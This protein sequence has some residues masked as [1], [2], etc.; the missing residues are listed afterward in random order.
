[1]S[2][3]HSS[4]KATALLAELRQFT[5]DLER[6]RHPLN[7]RLLYT[8]G[9]QFLAESAGA[10]W[11]IDAIASWIGTP[12]YLAAVVTDERINDLH[13]WKLAVHSN[14]SATL[15]AVADADEPPFLVQQIAYTDFCLESI[16]LWCGFDGQHYTLYL[17]SEH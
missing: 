7:P 10:Y 1:M 8:P 6:Y 16:D 4:Q 11:L 5:G 2:Q 15:S 14:Q 13:F 3:S 17:P 9:V 12:Q